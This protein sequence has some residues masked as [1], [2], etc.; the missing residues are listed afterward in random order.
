MLVE[1]PASQTYTSTPPSFLLEAI[2]ESPTQ[3]L[4][5]LQ[6]LYQR[7]PP[8]LQE[9]FLL[10]EGYD[11]KPKRVEWRYP[12]VNV[13]KRTHD[14]VLDAVLQYAE[15]HANDE[16]LAP[17]TVLIGDEHLTTKMRVL[18][19]DRRKDLLYVGGGQERASRN[20]APL[21]YRQQLNLFESPRAFAELLEDMREQDL[22]VFVNRNGDVLLTRTR[23]TASLTSEEEDENPLDWNAR[24]S[25]AAAFCRYIPNSVAI[26]KSEIPDGTLTVIKGY[27]HTTHRYDRTNCAYSSA[28]AALA[29]TEGGDAKT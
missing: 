23:I 10:R 3:A 24:H 17:L 7:L 26:V 5:I 11:A 15:R 13:P 28:R 8:G 27:L 2:E 18:T 6:Q 20:G 22:A 21:G 4:Q 25:S 29:T 9:Q 19:E 1:Q 12:P 16:R 14:A